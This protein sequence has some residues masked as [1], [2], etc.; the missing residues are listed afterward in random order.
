[1]LS[2]R[3]EAMMATLPGYYRGE[4]LIERIIQAKANE[5]DRLDALVD[6][7]MFELQPGAATDD[8]GLLGIWE[9]HFDLPVRPAAATLG[10]RQAKVHGALQAIGAVSAADSMAVLAAAIGTTSFTVTRNSPG[11]LQ[12]TLEVPFESTSYAAGAVARIARRLWPAH[13]Q[14]LISYA[15]GFVFDATPFDEASA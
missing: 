3:A 2:P 1:M 5:I 12:D 11:N 13:R 7:L 10:Q 15:G 8:L 9:A 6:K 14:L 4:P